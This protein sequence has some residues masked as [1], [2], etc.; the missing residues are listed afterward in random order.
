[1]SLAVLFLEIGDL[2]KAE[3]A[4]RNASWLDVHDAQALNLMALLSVRQNK[5]EEACKTQRRAVARQP[6]QPQ[7]YLLLSDILTKWVAPSK[8]TP[9]LPR[10]RACRRRRELI[11]SST[12]SA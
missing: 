5:L 1:M 6:D 7:Q 10:S 4:L 12:R 2:V 3:A 9:R 8:R 11:R